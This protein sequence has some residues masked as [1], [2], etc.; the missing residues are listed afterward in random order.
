MGD[1]G[2]FTDRTMNYYI[3][4]PHVHA[5]VYGID[6]TP[7]IYNYQP[8]MILRWIFRISTVILHWTF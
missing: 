4:Q 6:G 1:T 8:L 2:I 5:Y 7:N 3:W